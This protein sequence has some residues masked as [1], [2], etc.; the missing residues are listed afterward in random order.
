MNLPVFLGAQRLTCR[1]YGVRWDS[2]LQQQ[3]GSSSGYRADSSR[4]LCA[5][6]S[7]STRATADLQSNRISRRNGCARSVLTLACRWSRPTGT[8]VFLYK[9]RTS[10]SSF[11][12]RPPTDRWTRD[13]WVCAS[14]GRARG[15]RCRRSRRARHQPKSSLR[16]PR[17]TN[18]SAIGTLSDGRPL[19]SFHSKR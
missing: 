1:G 4:H 15:S 6:Q 17:R 12:F 14:P 2:I 11:A 5:M 18:S 3:P 9:A 10:A 16:S 7:R 19:G 8:A 13:W